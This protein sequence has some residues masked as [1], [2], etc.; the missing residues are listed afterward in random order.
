VVELPSDLPLA[1]AKDIPDAFLTVPRTI[2]LRRG[3]IDSTEMMVMV[4]SPLDRFVTMTT[5]IWTKPCVR[6][7]LDLLLGPDFSDGESEQ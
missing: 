4:Y 2:D 7:A 3:V 6:A 5:D 1:A